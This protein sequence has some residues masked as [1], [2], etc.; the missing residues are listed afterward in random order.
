MQEFVEFRQ[1]PAPP[2][3]RLVWPVWQDDVVTMMTAQQGPGQPSDLHGCEGP[4]SRLMLE[5]EKGEGEKMGGGR[6]ALLGRDGG[7][8]AGVAEGT[9]AGEDGV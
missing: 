4:G 8:R 6:G 7:C 5:E 1:I 2:Y 9:R 3:Y